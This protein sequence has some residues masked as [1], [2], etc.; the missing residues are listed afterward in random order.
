[1]TEWWTAASIRQPD[2]DI[3]GYLKS[4]VLHSGDRNIYLHNI[5]DADQSIMHDHPWP[6]ES[7]ILS[8]GY[9]EEAACFDMSRSGLYSRVR[10]PVTTVYGVGDINR[11]GL[12]FSKVTAHYISEVLPNTWSLV[13]TGRRV[14]KWGFYKKADD[15][16]AQSFYI[17]VPHDNAKAEGIV[18]GRPDAVYSESYP[19]DRVA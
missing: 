14:K 12:E 3:P 5:L 1:M 2:M 10:S 9:I 7:R 15:E 13:V 4:W 19:G 18:E 6:F 16:D 17:F 11:Y 8:G